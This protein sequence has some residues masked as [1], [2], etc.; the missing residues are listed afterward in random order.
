MRQFAHRTKAAAKKK[1]KVDALQKQRLANKY[2]CKAF[3]NA[4][5][6]GAGL[7]CADFVVQKPPSA[8]AANERRFMVKVTSCPPSVQ[9]VSSDR[10]LRSCI[11]DRD[12]GTTRLEMCWGSKRKLMH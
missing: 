2:H 6:L 4:L 9:A 3:D 5:H 1:P 12:T 7:S 10:E 11:Q 8:L